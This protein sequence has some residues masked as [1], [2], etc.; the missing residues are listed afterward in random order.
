VLTV[1]PETAG[2]CMTNVVY[3]IRSPVTACVTQNP[4]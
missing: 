4:F 2:A 3:V 1:T